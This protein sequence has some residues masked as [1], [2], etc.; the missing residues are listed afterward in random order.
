MAH[1]RLPLP[2]ASLL[3]DHCPVSNDLVKRVQAAEAKR[4]RAEKAVEAARDELAQALADAINGGV[5]PVDLEPLVEYKREH[6]RRIARAKGAVPL[7]ESTV[8][9]RRCVEGE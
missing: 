3:C 5:R 2:D 8:V 1:K 9:S 7:R 6:I 4:L